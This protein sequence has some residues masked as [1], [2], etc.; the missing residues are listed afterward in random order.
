[1]VKQVRAH[2]ELSTIDRGS[3][4]LLRLPHIPNAIPP[5][6]VGNVVQYEV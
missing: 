4:C 5:E 3:T 6:V 2:T 1:M